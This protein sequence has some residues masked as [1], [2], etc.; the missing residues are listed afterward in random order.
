MAA[1]IVP[2][3]H[4]LLAEIEYWLKAEDTAFH[5][6]SAVL[7]D[8][9]DPDTEIPIRGFYC[10]WN[11]VQRS[12]ARNPENV[13]VLLV[14]GAAVGFLDEMDIL[15][16]R[17]DLRSQGWGRVLADFMLRRSFDQGYSVA[18]IEIAPETALPFW[19]R[20]GFTPD[21]RRKGPGGGIYA[22][23]RF[24][25]RQTLG[26]GPRVPYRIAFHDNP[27]DWDRAVES[28]LVFEGQGE[29]L[30]DGAV[31]LP[32]R[33][34]AFDPDHDAS[35]DWVVTVE[36][37]GQA[38]YKDKV[39]RRSARAFGLDRDPGGLCYF[40]RINPDAETDDDD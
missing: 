23:R 18:E 38:V 11:L 20:M 32:E 26:P 2:A 25:R 40:D 31:R 12:F 8:R 10:N 16:V 22:F 29:R 1:E 13:Y 36:V 6:A 4:A 3:T 9:W 15:E 39:K 33:A 14:D 28:F 21:P 17:P 5:E 35:D 34:Y 30:V 37:D 19:M 7:A 27:R 24:E